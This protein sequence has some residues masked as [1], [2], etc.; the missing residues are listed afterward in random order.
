MR[1]LFFFVAATWVFA[2]PGEIATYNDLITATISA[3]DDP[4]V[5]LVDAFTNEVARYGISC[6]N[7]QGK[8]AADLALAIALMH[9]MEND[10]RSAGNRFAFEQHQNLVSNIVACAALG[11]GSWIRYAAAVEYI[12][13]LNEDNHQDAGF[14]L[15]TNMLTQI[16]SF[17]P[18]MGQTNYWGAMSRWMRCTNETLAVVFRMNAAIWL[19]DQNRMQEFGALTNSLPASAIGLIIDDMK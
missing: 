16:D 5:L 12:A 17:P 8:C 18:D 13:G 15:S 6:S 14:A 4:E 11:E 2:L 19:G 3:C 1:V 7:M 10:E 9:R